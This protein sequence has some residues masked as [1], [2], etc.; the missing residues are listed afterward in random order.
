MSK[1]E[2]LVKRL[3][4]YVHNMSQL[5][6]SPES[7]YV[8]TDAADHIEAQQSLIDELVGVLGDLRQFARP[9]NWDEAEAYVTAYGYGPDSWRALDAALARAKGDTE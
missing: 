1:T 7:D 9:S 6:G 2:E 8:E 4:E 5:S 3:R